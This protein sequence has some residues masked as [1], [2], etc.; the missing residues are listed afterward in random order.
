MPVTLTAED[1][2]T[3]DGCY[4]DERPWA[5][6]LGCTLANVERFQ[7]GLRLTG[8]LRTGEGV[9]F[10][11]LHQQDC[12]ESVDLIDVAGDL[13]DLICAPVL[14][15]EARTSDADPRG[16]NTYGHDYSSATWTFIELAT[17]KGSVTL[18]YYGASNGYY[19]ET[20]GLYA[21]CLMDAV[22]TH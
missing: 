14:V 2:M 16:E 20:A 5:A 13:G 10:A 1:S 15:S 19:S 12:C 8:S 21:C 22:T 7:G 6:L 4:L 3:P 18:R 11:I 17:N 9:V